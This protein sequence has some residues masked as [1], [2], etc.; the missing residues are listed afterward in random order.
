M[1]FELL[2]YLRCPK[3]KRKLKIQKGDIVDGY[4]NDGLLSTE[5]GE[6]DYPIINGIP[7]FVPKSTYADNFGMQWN[8][9]SKTQLDSHSGHDISSN[10][11]WKTTGWQPAD[12]KDKLVLDV[13]CGAGRFA[14]IALNAGAY[15]VALDYSTAVDACYNNLKNHKKLSIIQGDIYNLPFPAEKFDYVYSL[16]V[17]QH[18]PDVR[19]AFSNLP[20]M[21]KPGGK[22]CVDYYWKR[23]RTLMHAK[24]LFRPI[25]K[26]LPKERLFRWLQI[27][28][29]AMLKISQI[30]G[31]VPF[32]GV[33]LKRLIPVANYTDIFPL[34][35][36]QLREW[37]LLDTFDML[38]PIHDNPQ[39]KK[40][41]KE[42]FEVGNNF[43]DI[44]VFHSSHLVARGKKVTGVMHIE[45]T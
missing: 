19:L 30:L 3:S 20:K 9:F 43:L 38:S 21:V 34:T 16:G 37:A 13:G 29:P 25:T 5:N 24:Y 41:I 26:R 14:E 11:F 4:I 23:F 42:W 28:V 32:A 1:N 2:E 40:V 31:S 17:L 7:R 33:V 44:E 39:S 15:V 22:L 6:Y 35:A 12:L 8:Q 36:E 10:R 45:T 27:T 18:T